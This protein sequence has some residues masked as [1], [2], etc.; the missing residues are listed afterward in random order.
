MIKQIRNHNGPLKVNNSVV[1]CVGY[2]IA[3]YLTCLQQKTANGKRM[4]HRPLELCI[5]VHKSATFGELLSTT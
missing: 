2:M 5:Q 4:H 1:K 3:I